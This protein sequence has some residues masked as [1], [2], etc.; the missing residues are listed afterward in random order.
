MINEGIENLMASKSLL[1]FAVRRSTQPLV[2]RLAARLYI[3]SNRISIENPFTPL[4]A[5][6]LSRSKQSCIHHLTLLFQH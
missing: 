5:R 4:S 1:L 2:K 6:Q 3:E